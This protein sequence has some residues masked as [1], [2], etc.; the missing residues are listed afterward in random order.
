MMGHFLSPYKKEDGM[1]QSNI[2]WLYRDRG[3]YGD[4]KQSNL[5]FYG[6][7]KLWWIIFKQTLGKKFDRTLIE[8]PEEYACPAETCAKRCL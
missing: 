2:E 8:K 7:T 4:P 1:D 5:V 6:S 3:W